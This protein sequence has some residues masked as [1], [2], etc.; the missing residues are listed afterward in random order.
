[1]HKNQQTVLSKL[2]I[3]RL[4]PLRS[5]FE[6]RDVSLGCLAWTVESFKIRKV[7]NAQISEK[8]NL[9]YTPDTQC[10]VHLPTFAPKITQ[11]YVNRS[12]IV[13]LGTCIV[14]EVVYDMQDIYIYAISG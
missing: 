6:L 2:R 5:W 7:A 10:M 4:L 12:Y 3:R 8:D 13:S 14:T 1:M 11:M 9:K